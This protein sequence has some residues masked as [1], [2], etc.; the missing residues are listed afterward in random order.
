MAWQS[1]PPSIRAH[2]SQV[3]QYQSPWQ[4]GPP[5]SVPLAVRSPSNRAPG[6]QVPSNRAPGS[7]VPQYQSPWQSGPPVPEPLAVRPQYQSPWQSGPPV[8]EPLAVRSFSINQNPWQSGPPVSEPLAVRSPC[9]MTS[10]PQTNDICCCA[11][12][13]PSPTT[14][15]HLKIS[16]GQTTVELC[17]LFHKNV[18]HYGNYGNVSAMGRPHGR[19]NIWISL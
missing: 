16:R 17:V 8:S 5:V 13:K 7:Q 9:I 11:G 4:S 18:G 1:G 2:G 12:D 3:P 15:R 14:T 10:P 6:S 19:M